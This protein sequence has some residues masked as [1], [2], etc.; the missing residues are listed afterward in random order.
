M[1]R[2]GREEAKGRLIQMH[3]TWK[4][5]SA[6]LGAPKRSSYREAPRR[7]YAPAEDRRDAERE[8]HAEEEALAAEQELAAQ[9]A[10][11]V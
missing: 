7:I 9:D 4:E 3:K 1:H 5:I 2:K 11:R 10:S 6:A 8:A